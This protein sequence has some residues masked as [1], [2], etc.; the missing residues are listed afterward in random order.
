MQHR[1][2][3]S[4]S[5]ACGSIITVMRLFACAGVLFVIAATMLLSGCSACS[6]RQ[7]PDELREKTAQATA[8]LKQDAK[9]IA[10]GVREGM[11]RNDVVDLN[12]GTQKQLSTLPGITGQQAARIIANRPY[13]APAELVSKRVLTRQEYNK[14][15]DRVTVKK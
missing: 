14:I 15:R 11:S 5:Y 6:P 13:N 3:E 10:Q 7:N 1:G 8:T 9:A 12:T 2:G 4:C